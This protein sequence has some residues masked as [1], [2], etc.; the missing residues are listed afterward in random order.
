MAKPKQ[1]SI[2]PVR[3]GR[4]ASMPIRAAAQ[5][6]KPNVYVE[7]EPMMEIRPKQELTEG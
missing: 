4:K 6:E 1:A 5:D 7:G 3:A 2:N